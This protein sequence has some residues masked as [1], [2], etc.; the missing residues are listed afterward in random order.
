[1]K[2]KD[3]SK[4]TSFRDKVLEKMSSASIP[5]ANAIFAARKKREEAR[6]KEE[7]GKNYVPFKNG[8]FGKTT[9]SRVDGIESD[10]DEEIIKM[11]INPKTIIDDD[12]DK[13][14]EKDDDGV[15]R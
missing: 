6:R 12:I 3:L 10:P 14:R 7:M 15:R 1:M 13:G 2:D 9:G 8:S 4:E 5:D 11:E